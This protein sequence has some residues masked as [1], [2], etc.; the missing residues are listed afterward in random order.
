MTATKPGD[1]I[2]DPDGR[3]GTVL[4]VRPLTDLIEENRA[5]LRGLYEV[6]REQDEIDAVARDWRRRNDREHIRQA[7]NTVARENAGHVHIADIR[8]LLPGHIDPH[9][10]G[11]FICAQVRM[12][13][14][15][16][17]GD[18]RPNGQTRSRNRTKPAQ[19]YRLAAPIPEEE[20]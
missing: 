18:Y 9:Q 19:V 8:P 10:P 4:S 11:A 12:G 2:V 13:R 20:S 17:T 16:P 3:V 5:W 6:I 7:I 14:L 1:Q 15:I